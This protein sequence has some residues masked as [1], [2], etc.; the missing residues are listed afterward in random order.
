MDEAHGGFTT[1]DD[2]YTLKFLLHKHS[3]QLIVTLNRIVFVT[4]P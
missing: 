2:S 4:P 3:N 1:I